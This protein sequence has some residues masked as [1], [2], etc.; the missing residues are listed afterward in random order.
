MN[1]VSNWDDIT[2]V[3]TK[4]QM[5]KQARIYDRQRALT[6]RASVIGDTFDPKPYIAFIVGMLISATWYIYKSES[7]LL[8][9][10]QNTVEVSK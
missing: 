5:E 7:A 3:G 6:S 4:D 1:N 10:K 8:Q 2:L 9:C